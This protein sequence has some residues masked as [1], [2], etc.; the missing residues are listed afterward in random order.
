M[1][2]QSAAARQTTK[3]D[4]LSHGSYLTTMTVYQPWLISKLTTP[5]AM[6]ASCVDPPV[7]LLGGTSIGISTLICQTPGYR[8]SP[9]YWMCCWGSSGRSEEHTSE[10]QSLR[11]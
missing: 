5:S 3:T 8:S 11:H 6:M 7:W 1:P 2:R 9:E 10:L 4:R